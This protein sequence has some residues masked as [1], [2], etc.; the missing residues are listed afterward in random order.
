MQRPLELST[1]GKVVAVHLNYHSR[2]EERGRIPATPSYF[3]KPPSS[4]SA[5]GAPIVRPAGCEL[6]C[7]EG[8]IALVIGSAARRVSVADALAHVGW[9]TAANDLGVYDLRW[10]DRGSNVLAKG[11]DGFTPIGPRLVPASELDLDDL[12]VR[13]YVN[14]A[15][16]QEGHTSELLFPFAQ[17]VADLSRFMTL[18]PGD[19]ILTGTPANSRPLEPGDTV[20]VEVSGV[21]RIRNEV[22]AGEALEPIGAMPKVDDEARAQALGETG[23]RLPSEEMLDALR[24]V[25]TATLTT[26][27]QRRGIR[28]PFMQG[29]RPLR[30]D[31]RLVGVA[32]TLRYVA[33]R[34]DVVASRAG[35]PNAQRRAIEA[36]APGEVLVIEARNEAGA[37]TIGDI[38]ALRALRRGAAGIVTDGGVRDSPAVGALP[39]PTYCRAAHASVLG[40]HHYPLET[41]VPVS[42]AGVLVMPGDVIVGDAEGVMVVPAALAE[43]VARDALDQELVE[44]FA[45]ERVDAGES[46]VGVY[47]LADER[48]AE[49]EAWLAARSETKE[50]VT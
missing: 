43:E 38:L 11:Q 9:V 45:L 15:L 5:D 31:L 21:G 14:G 40:T 50:G 44:E 20:E 47:P 23:R 26:Q 4:L 19:V 29:L 3:L 41:N 32:H 1:V 42:C 18:E 8:E 2:A 39:I 46:T 12:A 35:A 7:Y 16:V 49:F 27:L 6:L 25:S 24:R 37:G 17:L 30:P 33:V 36:V 34:E 28:T 48:R 13:T 22:V 10:A